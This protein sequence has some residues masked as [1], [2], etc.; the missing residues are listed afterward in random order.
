MIL[1]NLPLKKMTTNLKDNWI[2]LDNKSKQNF[3]NLFIDKIKVDNINYL[4]ITY[5]K[6]KYNA[7]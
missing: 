2:Q 4:Q 1:I 7:N 6:W 3:V 5:L